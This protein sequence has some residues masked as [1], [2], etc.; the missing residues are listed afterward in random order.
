[1]CS[2]FAHRL[3]AACIQLNLV[4][5][6]TP[7]RDNY[8]WLQ[9]RHAAALHVVATILATTLAAEAKLPW[10]NPISMRFGGVDEN[11]VR[12]NQS[13]WQ[14]SAPMAMV[15]ENFGIILKFNLIKNL[16]LYKSLMI[17]ADWSQT[18][19]PT[20]M[21]RKKCVHNMAWKFHSSFNLSCRKNLFFI[22]ATTDTAGFGPQDRSGKT[23][24]WHFGTGW[25]VVV[26]HMHSSWC[27]QSPLKSVL[28]RV[29][30]PAGE[31]IAKVAASTTT[32]TVH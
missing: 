8:G 1:M 24:P 9:V 31:S 11:M 30:W 13:C 26:Q 10:Q 14:I 6:I 23:A 25:S 17:V 21:Q 15:S 28:Q 2:H 19:K 29:S 20:L 12:S 7:H 32:T 18:E 27:S 22:K 5:Q 16:H 4:C 3:V